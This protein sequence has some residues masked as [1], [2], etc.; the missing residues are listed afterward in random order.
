METLNTTYSKR[1]GEKKVFTWYLI[2][3][4]GWKWNSLLLWHAK[5]VTNIKHERH[6][7]LRWC[8]FFSFSIFI[9]SEKE[10]SIFFDFGVM[11]FLLLVVL[12]RKRWG[13]FLWGTDVLFIYFIIVYLCISWFLYK[14]LCV[15]FFFSV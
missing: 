5:Y 6:G 11:G 10:D 1:G 13:V 9:C 4:W 7:Q 15:I 14:D 3:I 12:R 8:E 2:Q